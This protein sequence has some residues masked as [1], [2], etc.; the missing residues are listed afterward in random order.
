MSTDPNKLRTSA[1]IPLN[2]ITPNEVDTRI[3]KLTYTDGAPI[4]RYDPKDPG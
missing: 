2:L 4:Q 3:G 1:D